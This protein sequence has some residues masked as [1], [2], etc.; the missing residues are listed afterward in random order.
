[1]GQK[2]RNASIR[3][4]TLPAN[5][6][7]VSNSVSCPLFLSKHMGS[8]LFGVNFSVKNLEIVPSIQVQDK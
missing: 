7:I 4:L 5:L 8:Q 2:Y 3:A 6:I 1:M